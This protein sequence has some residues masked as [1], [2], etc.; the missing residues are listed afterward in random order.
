MRIRKEENQTLD[1]EL[2]RLE[3]LRSA[4]IKNASQKEKLLYSFANKLKDMEQKR[5]EL[6][7]KKY[8]YEQILKQSED[9]I[10]LVKT[11]TSDNENKIKKTK[12]LYAELQKKLM[13]EKVAISSEKSQK[14]SNRQEFYAKKSEE[15][16]FN[17]VNSMLKFKQFFK[18][19]KQFFKD[20]E[21]LSQRYGSN[22][23]S[24]P[25]DY[26]LNA[27]K[28]EMEMKYNKAAALY[29]IFDEKIKRLTDLETTKNSKGEI[30]N[31][32]TNETLGKAVLRMIPLTS[33]K[34]TREDVVNICKYRQDLINIIASE[35]KERTKLISSMITDKFNQEIDHELTILN[36]QLEDLK[37]NKSKD[38]NEDEEIN[39]LKED[40]GILKVE[41][42]E[43]K[44]EEE[45]SDE[46]NQRRNEINL[47]SREIQK[48]I[49]SCTS[50]IK[51]TK[52]NLTQ[53]I[54]KLEKELKSKEN[55]KEL[56]EKILQTAFDEIIEVAEGWN[57]AYADW[58]KR[59]NIEKPLTYLK[60][61]P[62][63]ILDKE[64]EE[65]TLIDNILSEI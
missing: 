56:R 4:D 33:N 23:K 44:R 2:D 27:K 64:E 57:R 29:E 20:F 6:L 17:S 9:D 10:A 38:I 49:E 60:N 19:F 63:M 25:K 28:I 65:E 45:E 24:F 47:K 16:G 48:K 36:Q 41:I 58:K 53:E 52:R 43:G 26:E 13:D 40:L 5:E 18:D 42:K 34:F 22:I 54:S 62:K 46:W 15:L 21:T 50:N 31:E 8:G 61:A 3:S 1:F 30:M 59:E 51:L 39:D 7:Q 11:T 37:N 35:G 12:Q 14:K 55:E 32:I